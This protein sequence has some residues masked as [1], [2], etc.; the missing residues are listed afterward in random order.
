[1]HG[2]AFRVAKLSLGYIYDFAKTG[3]VKW[4]V[5]GL[6]SAYRAPAALDPYYGS[7]PRSY[8]VFLQARF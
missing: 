8:M 2:Q 4:G 6:V 1:L 7:K 5:G 3:P